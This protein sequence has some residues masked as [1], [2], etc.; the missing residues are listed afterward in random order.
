M[1]IELNSL[2]LVAFVP[3]EPSALC[4][5]HVPRH[6]GHV[7][8]NT[9]K[10]EQGDTHNTGLRT[11]EEGRGRTKV[12]RQLRGLVAVITALVSL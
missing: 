6:F 1:C 11:R 2:C 10:E 4:G 8:T 12:S 9:A 3:E 5:A 7:A